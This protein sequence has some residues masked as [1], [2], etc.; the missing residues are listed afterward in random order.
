MRNISYLAELADQLQLQGYQQV[1]LYLD[2]NP[3]HLQK[4]QTSYHQ[5]R[6]HLSIQLRFVHF[7][8]Y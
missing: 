8:A 5:Q 4:M 1:T 3:T 6:A 2:R 7:A